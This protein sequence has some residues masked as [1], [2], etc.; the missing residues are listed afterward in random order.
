MMTIPFFH[1][2]Q[3]AQLLGLIVCYLLLSLLF[4]AVLTQARLQRVIDGPIQLARNQIWQDSAELGELAETQA[5]FALRSQEVLSH[6]Q[7]HNPLQVLATCGF[8]SS[9]SATNGLRF[10]I[11]LQLPSQGGALRLAMQ[12][13]VHWLP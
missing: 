10:P 2:M 1:R 6:L 12:C 5:L 7:W 3:M 13:D 4:S 8:E 9:N 11:T